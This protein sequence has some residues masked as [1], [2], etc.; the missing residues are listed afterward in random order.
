M[1]EVE[2]V[3]VD[4]FVYLSVMKKGRAEGRAEE[5][6]AEEE[7]A[8]AEE[9]KILE[10]AVKVRW[11]ARDVVKRVLVK[12]ETKQGPEKRPKMRGLKKCPRNSKRALRGYLQE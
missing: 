6:K 10:R 4:V 9:T 12:G 1:A 5:E 2:I 3:K 8:E 11:S 7:K